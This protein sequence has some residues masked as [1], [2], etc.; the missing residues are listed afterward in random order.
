VC[1]GWREWKSCPLE[2]GQR[3]AEAEDEGGGGP[4]CRKGRQRCAEIGAVL[5]ALE[6]PGPSA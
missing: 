1:K 3:C 4:V 2:R 5:S 6:S